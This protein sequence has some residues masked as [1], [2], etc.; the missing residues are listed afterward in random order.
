MTWD[1]FIEKTNNAIS[2]TV[3][4]K[5]IT[6]IECPKC[7]RKLYRRTDIV[8]TTYPPRHQYECECGWIGYN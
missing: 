4:N 3:I 7:K 2:I 1:E 6:D 8:L 5:E